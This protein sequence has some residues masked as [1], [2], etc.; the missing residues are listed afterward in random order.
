MNPS[1]TRTSV[2]GARA[3]Y[4][5]PAR[6]SPAKNARLMESS[7]QQHESAELKASP[8][9]HTT[10]R[11]NTRTQS[12]WPRSNRSY[13]EV[14]VKDSKIRCVFVLGTNESSFGT[15]CVGGRCGEANHTRSVRR[16]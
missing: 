8:K 14:C 5:C 16:W 6:C 4:T 10:P 13:E 2:L 11:N 12:T 15:A 1:C 3:F 9:L 7:D